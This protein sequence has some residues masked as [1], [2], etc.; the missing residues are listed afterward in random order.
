MKYALA[1]LLALAC[2]EVVYDVP[3]PRAIAITARSEWKELWTKVEVCSRIQSDLSRVHWYMA[4]E[5]MHD[6]EGNLLAGAWYPPSSIYLERNVIVET[7]RYSEW[8][9]DFIIMHE[10]LHMK[11]QQA[12]HSAEFDLCGL[13]YENPRTLP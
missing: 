3:P 7:S 12:D 10:M 1:A 6:S 5:E 9:K 2:T 8:Y 4:T 11:L 13:R